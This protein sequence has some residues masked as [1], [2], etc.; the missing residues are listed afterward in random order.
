[1]LRLGSDAMARTR[2]YG[3]DNNN[4]AEREVPGQLL[5]HFSLKPNLKK[6]PRNGDEA[7][8]TITL[9]TGPSEKH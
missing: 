8:F 7:I 1:M 4:V 2:C 6:E 5:V 9:K 3:Y